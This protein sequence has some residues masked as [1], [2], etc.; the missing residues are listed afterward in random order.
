MYTNVGMNAKS[1]TY[2][3]DPNQVVLGRN[4]LR[5]NRKYALE[6]TSPVT[7]DP[8]WN[9]VMPFLDLEKEVIEEKVETVPDT[10]F[11]IIRI[12]TQDEQNQRTTCQVKTLNYL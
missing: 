5:S 3:N 11:V 2:C 1:F 10:E 9:N 4:V 8:V 12:L 6:T 7:H